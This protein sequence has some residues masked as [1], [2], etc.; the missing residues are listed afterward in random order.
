MEQE[1]FCP[2]CAG[3]KLL[4]GQTMIVCP[5]CHGR[6]K[7]PDPRLPRPSAVILPIEP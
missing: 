1:I 6:G 5:V 2:T 4:R 7:I 3:G